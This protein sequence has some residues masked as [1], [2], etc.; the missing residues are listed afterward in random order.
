VLKSKI[1]YANL[2]HLFTYTKPPSETDASFLSWLNAVLQI[3][4]SKKINFSS[5]LSFDNRT[6]LHRFSVSFHKREFAV[7]ISTSQNRAKLLCAKSL[8]SLYFK[9]SPDQNID[10]GIQELAGDAGAISLPLPQ[11]MN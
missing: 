6:H 11:R 3:A 8:Y 10:R 9:L 7:G 1:H 5:S 4:S 2:A